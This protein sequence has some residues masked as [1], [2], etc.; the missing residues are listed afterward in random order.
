MNFSKYINLPYKYEGRDFDGVD[1]YGLLYL[2]YKNERN[3][4]LPEYNYPEEWAKMGYNY[5][6]DET[7]HTLHWEKVGKP[8]KVFDVIILYASLKRVVANHLGIYIGNDKFIHILNEKYNSM[9]ER[10]SRWESRLYGV[11]RYIG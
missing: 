4:I 5:I 6:E 1:C 2:I 9:V 8:Y 7:R 10:L 11:W 3:I